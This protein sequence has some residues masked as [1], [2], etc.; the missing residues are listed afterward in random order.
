MVLPVR[1]YADILMD[2]N[3]DGEPIIV[4]GL[5]PKPGAFPLGERHVLLAISCNRGWS[6][7]FKIRFANQRQVV[8]YSDI[9]HFP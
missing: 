4:A 1:A 6:A 5:D 8:Y 7:A 3:E 9:L 2:V